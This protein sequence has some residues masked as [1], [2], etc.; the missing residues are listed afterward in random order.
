MKIVQINT[1][2]GESDSTGRNVK[3]L[4]EYFK[5]KGNES[6][7]FVTC[8]TGNTDEGVS[9]FS[10]KPDMKI[11]ALLSRATGL[12]G[13]FS[14]FTTGKLIKEI[15]IAR[16]DVIIL[17]VL[18]S[19]CINFQKLFRYMADTGIVP[20]IILHDCFFYTGHCCHY[21]GDKCYRWKESC[22]NC[23]SKKRWN[24]SWFFDKSRK[25]LKDKKSWYNWFNKMGVVAVSGWIGEDVK[26]SILSDADMAIIFNWVDFDIFHPGCQVPDEMRDDK[27]LYSA[28]AV[29]SYWS[30][31]KG[32]TEIYET[33]RAMPDMT[34]YM[35]GRISDIPSDITNIVL[36]GL[37]DD[38]SVLAG[39]YACADV[40][41]NPSKQE[42]FG[43]TTAESLSCGTPVVV[44][45]TT[46]CR[47]L[48]DETRGA[49]ARVNDVEDYIKRVRTVLAYGKTHYSDYA[50]R[51]SYEN[52]DKEKNL[53]KY[54]EFIEAL[55]KE[56]P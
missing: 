11:H 7:V 39:F 49:V 54:I 38:N 53:K 51:F 56:K 34:I 15:D 29:A 41:L 40:Y 37:I 30:E 3:E 17:N 6:R 25:S 36:V 46:A 20:V 42:T 23:P 55:V 16:P 4:H 14:A 21:I 12:Q 9:L 47:E 10:N 1:T 32:L 43:K 35:I 27:R 31:D 45:D 50:I 33:A 48:V 18:H 28:V 22:G 5:E 52:F 19:N 13:Y 44:Y 2:Y 8:V 24:T 26:E